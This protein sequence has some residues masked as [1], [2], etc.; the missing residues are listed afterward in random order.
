MRRPPV[1]SLNEATICER[2]KRWPFI[3]KVIVVLLLLA[4]VSGCAIATLV[5]TEEESSCEDVHEA[6]SQGD[7]GVPLRMVHAVSHQ[8]PATMVD[9]VVTRVDATRR[10]FVHYVDV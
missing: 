7:R 6:I 8:G 3:G 1:Y 9:E 10:R 5:E 2:W 4:G